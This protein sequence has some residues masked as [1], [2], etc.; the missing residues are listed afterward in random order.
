MG[1]FARVG[2]VFTTVSIPIQHLM[3]M[4]FPQKEQRIG[5][6]I[7]GFLWAIAILYNIPRFF[8]FQ[9]EPTIMVE[10]V[11]NGTI[12]PLTYFKNSSDILENE[13]MTA[14]LQPVYHQAL[15][16]NPIYVQ[17]YLFW[18]KLIFIELFPYLLMIS[19]SICV[20]K[21]LRKMSSVISG[22]EDNGK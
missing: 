20:R 22:V 4:K 19:V 6:Y 12:M 16:N 13:N 11:R 18:S 2:S 17:A 8:E 1:H 5:R 9:T 7:I 14:F 3:V 10:T 21:K 15:R